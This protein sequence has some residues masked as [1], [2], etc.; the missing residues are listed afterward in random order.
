MLKLFNTLS[1]E[2]EDFKPINKKEVTMYTCGPTVYD[3]AH[4]GNLRSYIFSDILKRTLIFNGYKVKHAM[5]ITDVGHLTSN[6]DLG[7]DKVERQ[8]ALESKSA[9]DIAKFYTE[10]FKDDLKALNVIEP[11]IFCQATDNIPEMIEFIKKL[12]AKGFI[13]KTSD[14]LYF[15]TSKTKDYGKLGRLNVAGQEEGSRVAVNEE[16]KNPT[17]FAVWKFS[18]KGGASFDAAQDDVA[19]QRQMEW[20]SPWAPPGQ[21]GK[22][23]GFPGWHI[24]C[25]AM[26]LKYLGEK[27]DIHTGAIDLVPVHH[28]NEIAQSEAL[29]GKKTVN[30]WLHG[31]FLLI[32]NGRMGKSEG[33]FITLKMV[34]EKGFDPIV[35]R[36]YNLSAHYRSKLNFTWDAMK[37][38]ANSWNKFKN[39]FFDLGRQPGKV[40]SVFVEKFKAFVNED[41]AMPQ[42]LA[43]A[44]DVFKS[45]LSDYDKRATLFEF[46]KVFGLGLAELKPEKLE[47]P[48]EV[49]ELI[50]KREEFRKAE[51]WAKADDVRKRIEALGY[52]VED[53]VDGPRAKRKIRS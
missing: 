17:D 44:W 23:Y 15:D 37:D 3:F 52:E 28:T 27:I 14:G 40:D 11:T 46:D 42:A 12:E 19:T 43:L 20:E 18:H 33:N 35:Y 25:S 10:S 8:A 30:Y 49:A 24:E 2:L 4:I 1:R 29:I 45:D 39:K 34:E 22:A 36:F 38:V 31:E 7:E 9:W 51:K 48:S 6:N 50:A 21:R 26:I 47:A 32:N 16:K 5:N 41:L 13:Y 53:A